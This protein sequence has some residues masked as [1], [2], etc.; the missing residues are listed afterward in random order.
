MSSERRI[1]GK[2]EFQ[3]LTCEKV[4]SKTVDTA[5]CHKNRSEYPVKC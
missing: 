4:Y 1:F 2:L 3:P 5:Y